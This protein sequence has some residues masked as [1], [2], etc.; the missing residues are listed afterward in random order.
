MDAFSS[1]DLLNLHLTIIKQC[2]MTT[3]PLLS[4]TVI[5]IYEDSVNVF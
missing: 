5:L 4:V 3:R 1:V 2:L